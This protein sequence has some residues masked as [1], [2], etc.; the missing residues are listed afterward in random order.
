MDK[1]IPKASQFY[2]GGINA[3]VVAVQQT[4][5]VAITPEWWDSNVGNDGPSDQILE[6]FD[7]AYAELVA[8]KSAK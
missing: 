6:R 2:Q 1:N 8:S 4:T 3:A 7:K 5:G